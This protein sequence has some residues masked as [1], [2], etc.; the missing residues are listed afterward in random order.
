MTTLLPELADAWRTRRDEV[1]ATA[2]E[3]TAW[4]RDANAPGAGAAELDAGVLDAAR[5]ALY[6]MRDPVHGGFG[7]APKFPLPHRLRFLLR[8]WKRVGDPTALATVLTALERMRAGGIHDQLGG[9]FHR[10]STDA[11]WLVPHF[12]KMLYDQ[13]LLVPA[14]VEAWQATGRADLERTARETLD[15]VLR[16][17]ADPAGGFRSAEDA[18]S[19]GE[20]GR[21]YV[22]EE[23]EAREVLA[24]AGL[25]ADAAEAVLAHWGVSAAGNF[26]G[27]NVLHLPGGPD[28]PAPDG[29]EAARR[30]LLDRAKHVSE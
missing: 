1:L 27:R 23:G 24:G 4:L 9:G 25:D 14:Y 15:Y 2:G 13:A 10:Y 28:A 8:E 12:E 19:E 20:E 22:W 6:G 16:E 18:D 26:E 21:F 5:E 17:L 30:A 3:V 7:G 29:L 11:R